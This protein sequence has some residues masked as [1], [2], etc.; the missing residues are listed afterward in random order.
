METKLISVYM[1]YWSFFYSRIFCGFLKING[2]EVMKT[3]CEDFSYC[4]WFIHGVKED[5]GTE[6]FGGKHQF[7]G[8]YKVSLLIWE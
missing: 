5:F 3:Y 7:D 6:R 8:L 2:E 4:E 1:L